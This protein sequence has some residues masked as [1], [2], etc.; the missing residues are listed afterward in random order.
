MSESYIPPFPGSNASG[1]TQYTLV[2]ENARAQRQTGGAPEPAVANPK[3]PPNPRNREPDPPRVTASPL[4]HLQ[5]NKSPMHHQGSSGNGSSGSGRSG[6]S[7]K[8]VNP[9]YLSHPSPKPSTNIGKSHEGQTGYNTPGRNTPSRN[10]KKPA[11]QVYDD[12]LPP[13]PSDNTDTNYTE[14]FSRY[15]KDNMSPSAPAMKPYTPSH[16]TSPKVKRCSCFGL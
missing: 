4:H 2:F 15:R 13:F 3:T 5:P 8:P 10:K 9:N 6:S 7:H 12:L 11:E 16:D 14:V 1:D